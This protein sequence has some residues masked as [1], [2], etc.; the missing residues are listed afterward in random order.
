MRGLFLVRPIRPIMI[1][2]RIISKMG[3]GALMLPS[4]LKR[5]GRKYDTFFILQVVLG[6]QLL[7][8]SRMPETG[9]T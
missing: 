3:L 4:D 9:L 1:C 6:S 8:S 5:A 7:F 2:Q